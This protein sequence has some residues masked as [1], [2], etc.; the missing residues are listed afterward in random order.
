MTVT[1]LNHE[2]QSRP[3]HRA[4]FQSLGRHISHGNP[5]VIMEVKHCITFVTV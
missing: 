4:G 2:A 1:V 3:R 5:Y